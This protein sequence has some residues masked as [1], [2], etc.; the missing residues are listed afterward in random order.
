TKATIT[1]LAQMVW[2]I[3]RVQRRVNLGRAWCAAGAGTTTPTTAVPRT[4]TTTPQATR[5]TTS[6]AVSRALP[7]PEL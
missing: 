3:Q 1:N 4:A 2:L 5:T 7:L 6:V